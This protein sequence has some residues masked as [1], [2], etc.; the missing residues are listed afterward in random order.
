MS[1]GHVCPTCGHSAK[2]KPRAAKG[3]TAIDVNVDVTSVAFMSL[4]DKVRFAHYTATAPAKALA[5]QIAHS[6]GGPDS[7][8]WPTIQ[9]MVE[10]SSTLSGPIATQKRLVWAAIDR[11]KNVLSAQPGYFSPLFSQDELDAMRLERVAAEQ[12]EREAREAEAAFEEKR[13]IAAAL[14]AQL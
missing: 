10:L 2:A 1:K 11:Y 14:V 9:A 6:P 8:M 4:P 13:A 7:P 3:V 12:A 5:F